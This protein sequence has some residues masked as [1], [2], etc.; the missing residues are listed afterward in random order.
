MLMQNVSLAPPRLDPRIERSRVTSLSDE[1]DELIEFF[2]DL[3][4]RHV[5]VLGSMCVG[6]ILLVVTSLFTEAGR[7]RWCAARGLP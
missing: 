4:A 6:A 1:I 3:R 5:Q 2:W 7:K